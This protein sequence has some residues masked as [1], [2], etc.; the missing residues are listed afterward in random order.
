MTTEHDSRTRIVLSW[1][2][3]DAHEN[4]ERMLLRALD[5]VDTTPQRRSWWP[6]W[7]NFHMN[8]L[9]TTATTLAAVLVVAVL[10]YTLLPRLGFIGQGA[11]PPLLAKGTFVQKDWGPVEFEANRAGSS[12]TGHLTVGAD[13]V[14]PPDPEQ[15][16]LTVEFECARTTEDGLTMIGGRVTGG[17]GVRFAGWPEGTL[18]AV[19]L[20]PGSPV[21]TAVW[22]GTLVNFPRAAATDCM[23]YLDAWLK[24]HRA[25]PPNV[26]WLRDDSKAAVEFGT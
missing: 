19:V 12:V 25:L 9:A 23:A 17:A 2:R 3:E 6:A 1:L 16:Y 22:V 10:G 18:A 26:D 24:W 4:A 15:G 11:A 5:E 8:K 14:T 20:K 7:R 13:A 21:R